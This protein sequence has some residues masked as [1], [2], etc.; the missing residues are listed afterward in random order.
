M[1]IFHHISPANLIE[2]EYTYPI[3]FSFFFFISIQTEQRK[4]QWEKVQKD[5]Q[6]FRGD[7][8]SGLAVDWPKNHPARKN[9]LEQTEASRKK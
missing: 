8:Y 7:V 2:I 5:F 1:L 9:G 6:L 4:E 3:A